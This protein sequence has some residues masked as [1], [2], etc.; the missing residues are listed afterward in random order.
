MK[1][2][3]QKRTMTN[4][5]NR[6]LASFI[7]SII[8]FTTFSQSYIYPLKNKPQL[9]ANFGELRSNHFHSGIDLK[10]NATVN[11]PVYSIEKGYVSRI[12]VSASGYGL[13]LYVTHPTGHTSVY[14]HLNAFSPKIAAY[15][16][17]KQYEAESYEIDIPV[18]A[19]KLPVQKGEQIAL[20][21]N[22]GGSAGPHVHF[23]IRD[24]QSEHAL[25]ALPFYVNQIPDT[26]R[27]SFQGIAVYPIDNKGIVNGYANPVRLPV[28]TSKSG[29]QSVNTVNAWGKIGLGIKAI[30][31][32]NGQSNV[33]GVKH[34]KVY[35]D[36]NLIY[37]STLNRFP[38]DKTRMLNTLTDFEN[39]KL[40]KSFY[41]RLYLE[42]GNTLP[43]YNKVIN[44]GI[45]DINEERTYAIKFEIEDNNH[46]KSILNF[47][48]NGKQGTIPP[49]PSSENFMMWNTDNSFL[50][51]DVVLTI[52]AHNLY[53]NLFFNYKRIETNTYLSDIHQINNLPV[54]LHNSASLWI[55]LKTDNLTNKKN[56]GVVKLSS[57]ENKWIGGVYKNGGVETSIREL[58]DKYAVDYDNISPVITPINKNNWTRTK[59]II[60]QAKDSKSGIDSFRG[61]VDGKFVLFAHDMKSSNYTY[62]F[63][64]KIGAPSN[65]S[66]QLKITV[67]DAAGNTTESSYQFVY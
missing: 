2:D 16:K 50:K 49:T 6:I 36:S 31:R 58:G 10:T 27:P 52:P 37:S 20:S 63:D 43:I 47:K 22:T 35:V 45:I 28:V 12:N 62:T 25:D 41:T 4:L 38:F 39:W 46:N 17:A 13:A 67:T 44:S 34:I 59:K 24:T 1:Y 40:R 7:I 29:N 19:N 9:S 55:K 64:E 11:M 5:N 21:G 56:Y 3:N 26:S 51:M 30:D 42:P 61:E 23:E 15:I 53:N 60:I 66:R 48:I 8:V 32:M 33:Y 18:P 65:Q 54:P 57:G 14:A